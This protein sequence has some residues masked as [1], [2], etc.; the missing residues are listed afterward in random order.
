MT[1]GGIHASAA[2]DDVMEHVIAMKAQISR[3]ERIR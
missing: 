2:R 1:Y 3:Q